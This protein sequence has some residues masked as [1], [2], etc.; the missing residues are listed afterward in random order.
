MSFS[1]CHCNLSYFSG[2]NQVS[3]T[4][5][6]TISIIDVVRNYIAHFHQAGIPDPKKE[7]INDS[8]SILMACHVFNTERVILSRIERLR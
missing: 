8:Q 1:H 5:V 7:S 6:M 4:L 3:R 2:F